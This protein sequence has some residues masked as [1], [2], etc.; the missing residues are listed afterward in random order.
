MVSL[1]FELDL[2]RQ[3]VKL[4][5]LVSLFYHQPHCRQSRW[6]LNIVSPESLTNAA[7][8]MCVHCF[9]PTELPYTMENA[10]AESCQITLL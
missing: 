3:V 4:S 9:I 6:L 2:V 8:I 5:P 10:F 1:G 7:R